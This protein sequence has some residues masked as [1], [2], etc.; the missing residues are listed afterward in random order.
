MTSNSILKKVQCG[1]CAY[2]TFLYT[3]KGGTLVDAD[4]GSTCLASL[5]NTSHQAK[6]GAGFAGVFRWA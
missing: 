5:P 2:I 1:S 3:T 4:P 6:Y